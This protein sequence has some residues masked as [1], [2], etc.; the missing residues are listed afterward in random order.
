MTAADRWKRWWREA[1]EN[2]AVADVLLAEKHYSA[3]AYHAVMGIECA[4]KA[5]RYAAATHEELE[6]ATHGQLGGY[7][8]AE[9]GG[10]LKPKKSHLLS[11]ILDAPWHNGESKRI[12]QTTL[13]ELQAKL[14]VRDLYFASRYP[15]EWPD[16][17]PAPSEIFTEEDAMTAQVALTLINTECR[18]KFEE[19]IGEERG[20][21]PHLGSLQNARRRARR[22]RWP[23]PR[24]PGRNP[25]RGPPG[26]RRRQLRASW[27]IRPRAQGVS[28]AQ[29]PD[30]GATLTSATGP[31]DASSGWMARRRRTSRSPWPA[32]RSGAGRARSRTYRYSL[33]AGVLP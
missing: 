13:D 7:T 18:L 26:G 6:R 19:R 22:P 27:R 20:G 12:T 10:G 9:L 11:K 17:K 21:T 32:R 4:A 30:G 33:P 29:G 24:P 1:E 16:D 15:D 14:E 31:V 2:E 23:K 25:L 3:A 5:L 28:A 8:H